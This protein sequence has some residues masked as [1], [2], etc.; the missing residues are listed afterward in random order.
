M[1][2]PGTAQTILSINGRN[3]GKVVSERISQFKSGSRRFIFLK[4]TNN[5]YK[6][7]QLNV[8]EKNKNHMHD[9]TFF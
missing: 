9:W 8:N 3:P 5:I 1:A 4:I 6:L 7:L 2:Q